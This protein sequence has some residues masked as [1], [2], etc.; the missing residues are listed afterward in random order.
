MYRFMRDG[1]ASYVSCAIAFDNTVIIIALHIFIPYLKLYDEYD[2]YSSSADIIRG[3]H[4][5]LFSTT[6]KLNEKHC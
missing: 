5:T 1:D 6:F 4:R 3:I 2:R